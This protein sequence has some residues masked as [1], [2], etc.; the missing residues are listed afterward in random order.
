MD[1]NVDWDH[2]YGGRAQLLWEPVE[3]FSANLRTY[4]Q[5]TKTGGVPTVDRANPIN[6]NDALL[7]K[8]EQSRLADE[9][10]NARFALASLELNFDL[11]PAA[12]TSTTSYLDSKSSAPYEDTDVFRLFFDPS[13]QA[14]PDV[15]IG[16]TGA[17][18]T[19]K[20]RSKQFTQEMRLASQTEGPFSYIIGLFYNQTHNN[21]FV[22]GPFPGFGAS[23]EPFGSLQEALSSLPFFPGLSPDPLDPDNSVR[24]LF[25]RRQKQ[26]AAFGE[27]TWKVSDY[28][29]FIGGG[30]Y[31]NYKYTQR[32]P[33]KVGAVVDPN[34]D[35]GRIKEDGFNPKV[36]AEWRPYGD[37]R[38][39]G[40]L[41]ASKG[42]RLGGFRDAVPE[43]CGASASGFRS[44]SIWNYEAGGKM[45]IGDVAQINAAA[46]RTD[47]S[48]IPTARTFACGFT[49]I[50]NAGSARVY[51][52]ET[53]ASVIV[54]RGLQLSANFAYTD[55]T[56]RND[57]GDGSIVAGTRLALVPKYTAGVTSSY[58]FPVGDMKGNISANLAYR[59]G[60]YHSAQADRVRLPGY[61]TVGG[62]IG[63]EAG[64]WSAALYV[65][66]L[67]DKYAVTYKETS[68]LF[69]NRNTLLRPRTIGL[70][71][72]VRY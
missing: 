40:Y 72:G 59:G 15:P 60:V 42:F 35:P 54:A 17:A 71:I 16:G 18:I 37:A 14:N 65:Q 31:F 51:G 36:S 39:L 5:K 25:V 32:I 21:I 27:L 33:Y 45:K 63:V 43:A 11:G 4:Y 24:Y 12:L 2:T 3:T 28:V 6:P 55:A 34:L 48:K 58:S 44:D 50:E 67:F 41:S 61:T 62:R 23:I 8:Y 13:F 56:Y 69:E 53:D 57:S 20:V 22:N 46:Y 68:F 19:S 29:R 49:A 38:M 64:N 9:G 70:N 52:F 1:R 10:L 26:Y 7:G 30:R 47:W 66:N